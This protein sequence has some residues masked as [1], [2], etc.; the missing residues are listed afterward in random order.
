M[1]RRKKKR[2]RGKAVLILC[3]LLVMSATACYAETGA[4]HKFGR[5]LINS[6]T[7]WF[8]APKGIYDAAE[9]ENIFVG[10]TYGVLKGAAKTIHRT[11]A[12]VYDVGTFYASEEK[13][14]IEPETLL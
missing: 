4:M 2:V 9:E 7:G 12:G 14:T 10:L 3:A 1:K 11:G 13:P 8:E 6:A 5:G